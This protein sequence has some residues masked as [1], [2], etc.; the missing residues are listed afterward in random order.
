MVDRYLRCDMSGVEEE[1]FFIEVALD[2]DLRRT[3]KAHRVVDSAMHKH[4]ESA[5][6]D[7]VDSYAQFMAALAGA[8]AIESDAPGSFADAVKNFV[9][10]HVFGIGAVVAFSLLG[11][12]TVLY[13]GPILELFKDIVHSSSTSHTNGTRGA[14]AGLNQLATEDLGAEAVT[15]IAAEPHTKISTPG[16]D[17]R[18]S[19]TIRF[20]SSILSVS[21][22]AAKSAPAEAVRSVARSL[23]AAQRAESAGQ[24]VGPIVPQAAEPDID[25]AVPSALQTDDRGDEANAAQPDEIIEPAYSVQDTITFRVQLQTNGERKESK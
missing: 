10:R 2:G 25:A 12:G 1:Q 11:V 19:G 3:L 5:R 15:G 7:G 6:T 9:G 24:Y 18:R 21:V 14:L 13:A 22:N 16:V 23:D 17:P 20:S 8:P 4:R